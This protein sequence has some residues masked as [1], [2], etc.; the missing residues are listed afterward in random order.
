MMFDDGSV[1]YL[2]CNRARMLVWLAGRSS[3][4]AAIKDLKWPF[5]RPLLAHPAALYLPLL[6]T[7]KE[8]EK[9]ER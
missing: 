3:R 8:K 7:Q 6:D 5:V 4:P 2:S 9:N 1:G